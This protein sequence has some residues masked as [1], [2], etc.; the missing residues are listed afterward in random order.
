MN[1]TAALDAIEKIAYNEYLQ[2]Y[3]SSSIK[4]LLMTHSKSI[5]GSR[6]FID[7]NEYAE[8]NSKTLRYKLQ[9]LLKEAKIEINYTP[10]ITFIGDEEE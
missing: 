7:A 6:H 3:A 2:F 10:I 1:D 9:K 8:Y 5:G 4:N